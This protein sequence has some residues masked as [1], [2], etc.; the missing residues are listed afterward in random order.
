MAR[1]LDGWID[2]W[3]GWCPCTHTHDGC[4]RVTKTAKCQCQQ[5]SVANMSH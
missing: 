3:M 1:W 4:W 2:E 5:G